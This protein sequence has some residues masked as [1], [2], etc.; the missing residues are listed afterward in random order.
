MTSS[1]IEETMKSAG[2]FALLIW[3]RRF[4]SGPLD[5]VVYAALIAGGFA[6]T[7][8]YVLLRPRL[9]RLPAVR[10]ATPA[11]FDIQTETE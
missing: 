1:V 5:G 6:F 11:D 4:I 10:A 2:L 8:V 3:G 9:R 7:A